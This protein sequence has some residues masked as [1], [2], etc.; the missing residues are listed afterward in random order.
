MSKVIISGGGGAGGLDPDELTA[1][2]ADVRKGKIAGVKGSDD[3]VTGTLDIPAANILAGKNIGGVAGTATSDA[4]AYAERI[5]SGHTAYV[6]GNKITGNMTCNS[7]LNFSAQA[8]STSQILLQWQNPYAATGKPF[9]GVFVNYTTNGYPGVHS[10]TR[11]YTGYGNNTAPGG[12]SQV[13]V[14]MPSVGTGYYFSCTAYVNYRDSNGEFT[15]VGNTINAYAATTA[16]G[17]LT[18][19]WSQTWTVPAGIRL[20]DVCCVGGGSGGAGRGNL[21]S[22]VPGGGGAG[23]YVNNWYG[24]GVAPGQQIAITIGAGGTRGGWSGSSTKAPVGGAGGAT[25]FGA[26]S[27]GG[28]QSPGDCRTGA[29]GGSGGGGGGPNNGGSDGGNGSTDKPGSYFEAGKGQGASTR[30]FGGTLY[31]GGGGGGAYGEGTRGYGGS[32]GGGYGT[33]VIGSTTY[34]SCAGT[35]NTGGGGGGGGYNRDAPNGAAGGS[36]IVIVRW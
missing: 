11:I 4:N 31:A 35:A 6:N 7:I 17:S 1:V 36:G 32:G 27:A 23:G 24:I 25:A 29:S 15:C 22:Y 30:A 9:Q 10:G 26:Y 18:F 2:A 5:Y 8:Y 34:P 16:H 21:G 3:P 33:Y 12:V 28:G 20:V 13:I 19:T 14:T